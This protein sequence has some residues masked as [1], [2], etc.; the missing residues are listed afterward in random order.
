MFKRDVVS[1]NMPIHLSIYGCISVDTS[2]I[3]QIGSM[4]CQRGLHVLTGKGLLVFS[5]FICVVFY[6]PYNHISE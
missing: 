1:P 5:I 2:S 6:F 3:V 4:L